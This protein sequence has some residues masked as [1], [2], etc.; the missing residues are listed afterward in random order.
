[1]FMGRIDTT[2]MSFWMRL[3]WGLMGIVGPIGLFFLLLGMW[4]YWMRLDDSGPAAKRF[5]FFVLLV[6]FWYGSVLYFYSVYL[7]QV[8]RKSNSER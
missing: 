5:W 4:R 7:P 6:G 8:F 2:K 1:M 3:P